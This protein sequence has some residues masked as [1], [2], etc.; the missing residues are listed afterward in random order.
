MYFKYMNMKYEY[1]REVDGLYI[2]FL[3]NIEKEMEK[4]DGDIWPKELNN[5]IG[6]IFNKTGFLLGIEVMP[7]TKY[8]EEKDLKK[9]QIDSL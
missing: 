1:D 2:W 5:E 7:A 8:F 3:D 4:Y 6:L 9:W